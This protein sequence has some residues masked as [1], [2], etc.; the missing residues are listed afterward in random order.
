[1]TVANQSNVNL[2]W[3]DFGLTDYQTIYDEQRSLVKQRQQD[4]ISDTILMGE[5]PS[6]LTVGRGFKAENLLNNTI[7]VVE[8]ERGGDITYHGPGQLVIYPILKLEGNQKDLHKLLRNLEEWVILVLAEFGVKGFRNDGWTGVWVKQTKDAA[9]QKIAS[10]GVAVKQ[11]VTFHGIGFN[12][13]TDLSQFTTINPC[14]LS[15]DTMVNLNQ[16]LDKPAGVDEVKTAFQKTI[17]LV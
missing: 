17:K 5:H 12:V 4:I 14:G 6:I 2:N 7:P 9:P 3:I 13:S 10:I 8:I 15:S 11:W 16:L 1:M